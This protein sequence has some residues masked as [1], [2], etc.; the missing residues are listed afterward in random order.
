MNGT[1]VKGTVLFLLGLT[2]GLGIAVQV[3]GVPAGTASA[4]SVDTSHEVDLD[5]P[6]ALAALRTTRPEDYARIMAIF[7]G[8]TRHPQKDVPHWLQTTFNAHDVIYLPVWLTSFPPKRRLS[9]SLDGRRYRAIL[10]VTNQRGRVSPV[11]G[12]TP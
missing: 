4:F 10:T 2:P 12:I 8:I 1:V 9:F 3:Q 11:E 7:A 5:A 6:G